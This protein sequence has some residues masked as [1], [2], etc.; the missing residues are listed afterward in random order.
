MNT[1]FKISE[2]ENTNKSILI[3]RANLKSKNWLTFITNKSYNNDIYLRWK[4]IQN[5][6]KKFFITDSGEFAI[7]MIEPGDYALE[8]F[9]GTA[10]GMTI[11]T[12]FPTTNY[13]AYFKI[14][15][16]EILYCGD[17][18][19]DYNNTNIIAKGI[20]LK[21]N[22]NEAKDFLLRK[23]PDIAPLLKKRLLEFNEDIKLAKSIES[24][25]QEVENA[26]NQMR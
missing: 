13:F 2:F 22:F 11:S 6:E 1:N 9:H 12:G 25:K 24:S 10:S 14:N 23:R 21:D 17:L 18:I 19:F 16:K 5:N 4:K 8:H 20:T 15:P 26:I 7:Y 3:F